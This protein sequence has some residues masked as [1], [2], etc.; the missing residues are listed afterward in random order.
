VNANA[1]LLFYRRRTADPLGGKTQFKV[2]AA[3]LQRQVG[4]REPAAESVT[5]D[6]QDDSRDDLGIPGLTTFLPRATEL[7]TDSSP[8]P[9]REVPPDLDDTL[10]IS[11][12]DDPLVR[13]GQRFDFPDPSSNRASPASSTEAEGDPEE[14]WHPYTVSPNWS[15]LRSPGPHSP[16][17][18]SSLSDMN[19]FTDGHAE[20]HLNID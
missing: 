14:R 9:L 19:P 5:L 10:D 20:T 8:S 13:S 17:E 4:S 12:A 3:R 16:S 15:P 1:Y 18:N 2:D 11:L 7:A 6:L